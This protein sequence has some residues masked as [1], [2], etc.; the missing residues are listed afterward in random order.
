MRRPK[1][2]SGSYLDRLEDNLVDRLSVQGAQSVRRGSELVIQAGKKGQTSGRRTNGYRWAILVNAAINE[3]LFDDYI[4]A[5]L[6]DPT[7]DT[8]ADEPI[9]IAKAYHL[10]R[11]TLDGQ[12]VNYLDGEPDRTYTYDDNEGGQVRQVDDGV[13]QWEE[14]VDPAWYEGELIRIAPVPAIAIEP[15]AEFSGTA[16][17]GGVSPQRITRSSGSWVDDGFTV[18]ATI[19]IAGTANNDGT[20]TLATVGAT[21]MTVDGPGFITELDVACTITQGIIA[22]WQDVNREARKFRRVETEVCLGSCLE[23]DGSGCIAFDTG[24]N[25]TV[26]ATV[27]NGGSL[28]IVAGTPNKLRLTL[29]RVIVTFSRNACGVLVAVGSQATTSITSDL[30]LDQCT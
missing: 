4:L 22:N 25:G 14:R 30:N 19:T 17:F 21:L 2:L 23:F 5:R 26:Q 28:S 9:V 8:Y 16:T 20:Y 24:V 15:E 12:T 11:S 18:G 1:T 10:M 29:T 6:W 13:D 27:V 3:T 7:T